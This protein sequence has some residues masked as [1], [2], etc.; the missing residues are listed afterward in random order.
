MPHAFVAIAV[1][2]TT[3]NL[4]PGFDCLGAALTL[5]NQFEF[6]LT[7]AT[8]DAPDTQAGAVSIQVSGREASRVATDANNLAYRAFAYFYQHL[9]QVPPAVQIKIQLGIPLARGLGSSATAI[10]AGLIAANYLAGSP[11]DQQQIVKLAITLEGHPDNVVPAILGGCR[12]I[13]SGL[14]NGTWEI[15]DIEWSDEI[16]PIVVIPDFEL[17]TQVA[18]QA[19]PLSCDHKDAVFNVAH[20][21]LLLRGLE[22]G[23]PNWL[24]AALQDRLH[25]PYRQA[26][27]PGYE[28][29]QVAALEAG[30]YG[31][32]ISGAGPTL[33]ALVSPDRSEVVQA[34]I[35]L[36][37]AA[38]R[39]GAQ[40]YSLQIDSQG[41]TASTLEA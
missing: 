22:T 7:P 16:I 11:L 30:A 26:L 29:V 19:L 31:L 24:R 18:R 34:Q 39:I 41:A 13:A 1:P 32:V 5:Y 28:A 4:G 33:L 27:I 6:S 12:L 37:W 38:L 10:V 21:G 14:E 25:Q 36:A 35:K 15:C 2:A 8:P 17:S 20:L 3:A 23:H 9:G 40:V